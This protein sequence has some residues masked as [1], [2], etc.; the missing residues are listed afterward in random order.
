MPVNIKG[1]ESKYYESDTTKQRKGNDEFS[2]FVERR[3]WSMQESASR[4]RERTK[5][6]MPLYDVFKD[7]LVDGEDFEKA[8]R[9]P[10]FR[11]LGRA[12]VDEIMKAPPESDL[13]PEFGENPYRAQA[14][15]FKVKDIKSNT[16]EKE[17]Q[18]ECLEDMVFTGEGFRYVNYFNVERKRGGSDEVETVFDDVGTVRLDPMDCFFDENGR[19]IWNPKMRNIKRDCVIRAEMPR[20]TFEDFIWEFSNGQSKG[21]PVGKQPLSGD[22]DDKTREEQNEKKEDTNNVMAY[23]Y[24]NQADDIFGVVANRETVIEPT[25]IPNDHGR[26]PVV[27]YKFERRRDDVFYGVSLGEIAAPYI[28]LQD[29]ILNLEIMGL[30]LDLM[31]PTMIDSELGYNKKVHKYS[32][33][34]IWQMQVPDGKNLSAMV[35]P[36][37]RTP[38][39]SN[40]FNNMYGLIENQYTIST[41]IDR[42]ALFLSPDELATQTAAKN[43]SKQKRINTIVYR[44]ELTA[45]A[46]LTELMVSDIRQ[47]LTGKVDKRNGKKK[48][49]R[50][51]K[52]QVKGY[53]VTQQNDGEAKFEPVQGAES[54]FA[55]TPES[56][57]V[58]V[59]VKARSVRDKMM[60]Q[61]KKVDTMMKFMPIATNFVQALDPQGALGLAGRLD[62]VGIFEQVAEN[63]ELD[64]ARTI[65]AKG[66]N[67]IDLVNREHIAMTLGLDVPVPPDETYEQSLEHKKQHE[68]LR[69]VMRNGKATKKETAVWKSLSKTAK[70]K[71]SQHYRETLQNIRAKVLPEREAEEQAETPPPAQTPPPTVKPSPT[72]K[73][74]PVN[75]QDQIASKTLLRGAQ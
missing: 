5:Q 22:Y 36:F 10:T 55:I 66:V 52:V 34:A 48:T 57:D 7:W 8:V 53:S 70:R 51:R 29:T 35:H 69:F 54:F 25:Y 73:Q 67:D 42:R 65:K 45:E 19:E 39:D 71:W 2:R 59:K 64:L 13:V 72:P 38:R 33:R 62:A 4:W 46:N 27:N 75:P 37:Q 31:P 56:V 30:K 50:H 11:D 40:G 3:F 44:N 18:A 26:I 60:L 6:V 47:Y 1:L 24:F 61:E 63:M 12:L 16:H 32:P 17:V 74:S 49:K 41:N 20:S 14:L 28:Y 43:Q 15:G 58:K 68:A 9:F 21:A 23:F